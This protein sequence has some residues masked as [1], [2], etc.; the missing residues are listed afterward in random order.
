MSNTPRATGDDAQP[1]AELPRLLRLPQV[2]ELGQ[3]SLWTV[4]AEIARGNL[5]ARRIGRCL[6]VTTDDYRRWVAGR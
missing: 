6:R 1:V 4:R 5:V 2:A 3:V